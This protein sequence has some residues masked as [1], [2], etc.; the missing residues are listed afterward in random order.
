MLRR[1]A[2]LLQIHCNGLMRGCPRSAIHNLRAI[3]SIFDE[4]RSRETIVG[5]EKIDHQILD[6]SLTTVL[7]MEARDKQEKENWLVA[8]WHASIGWTSS[9]YGKGMDNLPLSPYFFCEP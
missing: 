6:R 4:L 7:G 2:I 5:G 3:T 8:A 1:V 9:S